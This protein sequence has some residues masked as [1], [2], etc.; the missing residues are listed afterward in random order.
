MHWDCLSNWPKK[1]AISA[2]KFLSKQVHISCSVINAFIIS[3]DFKYEESWKNV[4]V[5]SLWLNSWCKKSDLSYKLYHTYKYLNSLNF[6]NDCSHKIPQF[7]L[8][9]FTDES[10]VDPLHA[11][12]DFVWVC[13][14]FSKQGKQ[15]EHFL[16]RYG[17]YAS[18][19]NINSQKTTWIQNA[20]L[21]PCDKQI[22]L[23]SLNNKFSIV[24]W[25]KS[26]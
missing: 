26:D 18:T 2:N 6:R 19:T 21:C 3:H 4:V 24:L 17:C 11:L 14:C 23:Y 8:I 12:C 16:I 25:N 5:W 13:A 9:F 10:F 7:S 20:C 15:K 22:L 1:K